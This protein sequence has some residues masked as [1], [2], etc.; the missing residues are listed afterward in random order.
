MKKK[1]EDQA[2]QEVGLEEMFSQIEGVLA[3]LEEE[4]ASLEDAFALYQRGILL[5]KQCNDR[6][7]RVEKELQ[8]LNGADTEEE[9]QDEL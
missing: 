8:I 4:G 5:V 2:K 6:I 1:T 9:E 7:D 3:G